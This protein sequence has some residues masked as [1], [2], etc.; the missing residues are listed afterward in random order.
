MPQ[1]SFYILP[2]PKKPLPF[3]CQL[4]QTVLAKSNDALAIICPEALLLDLDEKLWSFS[5]TA[6]IPH[7]IVANPN[8]IPPAMGVILTAYSPFVH[9]FDGIMI[10]LTEQS[11]TPFTGSRLLEIIAFDEPS[12][13]IG[14]EKYRIYQQ[15][16]WQL[17]IFEI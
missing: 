7:S 12:R 1:V 9:Q 11:L 15:L 3:T 8:D 5:D 4:A 13:V 2:E 16:G 6:F 17:T 14:R 10:N